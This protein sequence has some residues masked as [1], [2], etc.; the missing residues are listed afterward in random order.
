MLMMAS[1]AK[2]AIPE[3]DQSELATVHF[4]VA[5]NIATRAN[6]ATGTADDEL[7]VQVFRWD[8]ANAKYVLTAA[9]PSIVPLG[10]SPQSWNVDMQLAKS[11][12][13][14]IAFWAQKSGTGIYDTADLSAVEVDYSKIAVNSDD[15]DAF[16]A[17]REL[18]VGA[19]LTGTVVLYRPLAQI[20]LG[21]NDLADYEASVIN[22]DEKVLWTALSF[23]QVPS[24][25]NIIGGESSD[26]IVGATV[27]GKADVAFPAVKTLTGTENPAPTIS[28]QE[29]DTYSYLSMV[30]VLA[31][32]AKDLVDFYATI[33]NGADEP[34]ITV[35][36]LDIKNVPYQANYR[37]NIFGQLL[38]GSLHYDVEIDPEFCNPD[39]EVQAADE[40][41]TP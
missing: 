30:Y 27:S 12:R 11:Y 10:T 17:A 9:A 39:Y 6:F 35:N 7:L 5:G 16:C 18:T 40:P 33:S 41:V 32:P 2:Q 3:G 24:K 37:T 31:D 20:N 14:R 36:T 19:S 21:A 29:G 23:V 1:C 28:S 26:G 22:E 8:E 38:T 4:S 34:V 25:L 15:A 13:Y